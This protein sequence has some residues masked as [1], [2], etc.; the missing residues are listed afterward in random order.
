MNEYEVG[1]FDS[2]CD[3]S[4]IQPVPDFNG[5]AGCS[6]HDEQSPPAPGLP[7]PARTSPNLLSIHQR[8][9]ISSDDFYRRAVG[10]I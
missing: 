3:V 2:L 9:G 1:S 7:V 4:F 5:E 10:Q 8:Q 6:P